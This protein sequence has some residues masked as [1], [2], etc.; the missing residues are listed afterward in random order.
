MWY[1]YTHVPGAGYTSTSTIKRVFRNG[2]RE[3]STRGDVSVIAPTCGKPT[4]N[5]ASDSMTGMLL[6]QL[7]KFL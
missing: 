4:K 1:R 3:K 7:R 2:A 6:E 5:G